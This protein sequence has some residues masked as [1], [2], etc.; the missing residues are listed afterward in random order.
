MEINNHLPTINF[1]DNETG[2]CP[3]FHP[4]DW[5][6]KIFNFDQLKFIKSSTKSFMYMPLDMNKVMTRTM[7]AISLANANTDEQYL[8]LS[9]DESKWRC[10]HYFLVSSEVPSYPIVS[11]KGNYYSKVFDGAFKEIPN[12]MKDFD[13]TIRSKGLG[14]QSFMSFYTTCPKCAEHYG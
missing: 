11:L 12:F 7:E 5:D 4:E 3:R 2:C 10:D 8:I 1:N 14:G 6:G 13:K 9:K